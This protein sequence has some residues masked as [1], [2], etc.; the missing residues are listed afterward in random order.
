MGLDLLIFV[1]RRVFLESYDTFSKSEDDGLI[2]GVCNE[3]FPSIM[4]EI[5][6]TLELNRRVISPRL[7]IVAA[8]SRQLLFLD[9]KHPLKA[10]K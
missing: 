8:A 1:L 5:F 7:K 2:M 6:Q 10:I 9:S 3:R 4:L